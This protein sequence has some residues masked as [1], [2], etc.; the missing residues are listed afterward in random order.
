M[1]IGVLA[2]VAVLAAVAVLFG[3][4]RGSEPHSVAGYR[5]TLDTLE[6]LRDRP[7]SDRPRAQA[8]PRAGSEPV[9]R[10]PARP[11]PPS[12]AR[13]A[14][15]SLE[16]MN[17]EPRRLG[18]PAAAV[19]LLAGVVGVLV[20][21]GT[22]PHRA[23]PAP[24]TTGT[25]APAHHH[26]TSAPTTSTTTTLPAHYAP[27]ATT[28]SSA[29]YAPATTSYTLSVGATS[30]SCWMSVTGPNGTTVMTGTLTSGVTRSFTVSGDVT[31]L[32]GAP[33]VASL[34]ID[35][36]PVDLPAGA[37]APFTVSLTPS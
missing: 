2:G 23:T 37:Q 7:R 16:V 12:S 33:S 15:R 22:R 28:T 13:R 1:V 31:I 35:H 30:G 14:R 20:Y 4:R 6:H 21:V 34:A 36:V 24:S 9:A 10:V 8:D 5:Q 17:R 3:R 27:V 32:I 18:A 25:T 29:T 19:L 26:H 11:L